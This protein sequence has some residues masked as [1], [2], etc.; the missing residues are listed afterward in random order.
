MSNEME[1]AK[2][3][4]YRRPTVIA[5]AIALIVIGGVV[6]FLLFAPKATTTL[7]QSIDEA[8][9]G[10]VALK[11]ASF[12]GADSF[13][14]VSGTVALYAGP[15]GHFLRFEGYE[16]TSG[17][18]VYFYLSATPDASYNGGE[19]LKVRFPGGAD[20]GQ[21]TLR[22]D[23]NVP[24]PEAFDPAAWSSAIVWCDRF[25]V[26]FGSASFR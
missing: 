3:A 23:F 11:S 18:D 4:W 2:S 13:H 20:D 10:L 17:P 5:G 14:K 16:A 24:L 22:G 26:R 9:P 1:P 7:S 19:R 12:S 21:A 15:D 25:S 8:G 6:A